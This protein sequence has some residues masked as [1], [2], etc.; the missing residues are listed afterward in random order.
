MNE[1]APPK[2]PRTEIPGQLVKIPARTAGATGIQGY[3]RHWL[4]AALL[5]LVALVV[6]GVARWSLSGNVTVLAVWKRRRA[7]SAKSNLPPDRQ[8]RRECY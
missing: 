4:G 7:R 8:W 5:V 6:A 2:A 3:E 1:P